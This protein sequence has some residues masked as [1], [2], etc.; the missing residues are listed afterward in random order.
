MNTVKQN[1]TPE[2]YVLQRRIGSTTFKVRIHFDAT[3]K[4]TL[5][6]KIRRLLKNELQAAP[7]NATMESLQAGWLP[8]REVRY[9]QQAV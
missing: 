2:P 9:E 4:E 6:D 1:T 3:A 5:D 8:E 7:K